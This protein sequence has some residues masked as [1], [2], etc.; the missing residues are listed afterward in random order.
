MLVISNTSPLSYLVTIEHIDLLPRLF[1]SIL[2]PDTVRD[3]LSSSKA[4]SPY[5]PGLPLLQIG[6]LFN[7]QLPRSMS[8]Y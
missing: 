7:H 2:I 1:G 8:I 4:P 3:E 5:K 6:S